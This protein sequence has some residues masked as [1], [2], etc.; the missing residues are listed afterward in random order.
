MVGVTQDLTLRALDAAVVRH[1]VLASNI[2]NA[3]NPE[4]VPLR[5]N[6]EDQLQLLRTDLL[7]RT[8]ATA[9][10]QAL[11]RVEPRV[12]ADPAYSRWQHRRRA[13]TAGYG[14]QQDDA[15]RR[16]LPVGAHGD[17]QERVDHEDGRA[18][19]GG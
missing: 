15:E 1:N 11:A 18:P 16:V 3:S 10:R 13:D 7:R 17:I 19:R 6:F 4:Y 5:V 12:E 8:D 2:A 14:D 9:V